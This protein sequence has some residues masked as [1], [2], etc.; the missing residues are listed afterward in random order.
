MSITWSLFIVSVG[1]R[2][3][4]CLKALLASRKCALKETNI[5]SFRTF[6]SHPFPSSNIA[7]RSPSSINIVSK[8]SN[9]VQVR[10]STRKVSS[11]KSL[12]V[13]SPYVVKI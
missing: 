1:V 5:F 6:S 2:Y 12:G 4:I 9:D 7:A 10:F 13:T 11:C 8:G 3:L